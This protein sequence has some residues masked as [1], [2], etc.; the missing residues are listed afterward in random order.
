L[1]NGVTSLEVAAAYTAHWQARQAISVRFA[2]A[3]EWSALA[4]LSIPNNAAAALKPTEHPVQ[5]AAR[6][7]RSADFENAFAVA[8]VHSA[9]SALNSAGGGIFV[10]QSGSSGILLASYQRQAATNPVIVAAAKTRN[11]RMP[12]S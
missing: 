3:S 12:N 2:D 4:Q 1:R 7:F 11:L 6:L 10:G 8:V 9:C 5:S